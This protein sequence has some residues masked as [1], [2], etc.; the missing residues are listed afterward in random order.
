MGVG[1]G[2]RVTGAQETSGLKNLCYGYVKKSHTG[3]REQF[4]ILFLLPSE[5]YLL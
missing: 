4:G 1:E 5:I 2:W 3:V